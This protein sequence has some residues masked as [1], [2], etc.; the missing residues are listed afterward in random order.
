MKKILLIVLMTLIIPVTCSAAKLPENFC[1]YNWGT[2]R[3]KMP[4]KMT[5]IRNSERDGETQIYNI[6]NFKALDTSSIMPKVPHNSA[7][8]HFIDNKLQA[9]FISFEQQYFAD[10]KQFLTKKYGEPALE[11]TK[12]TNTYTWKNEAT[13]IILFM[14]YGMLPE[15]CLYET[16]HRNSFD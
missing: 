5:F 1:G 8:M 3:E 14:H 13:T 9:G 2:P 11:A 7:I 4:L 12:H 6:T 10:V 15:L 16:L